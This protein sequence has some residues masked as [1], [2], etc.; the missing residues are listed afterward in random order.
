MKEEK[1]YYKFTYVDG[2]T[3]EFEQDDNELTS[4]IKDSKSNRIVINKHVLINFNNVIKVTTETKSEREEK[5]RITEEKLKVDAEA[6]NKI[7]F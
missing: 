3:E 5:E 7:R 4:K 6:I 1:Y 2:T